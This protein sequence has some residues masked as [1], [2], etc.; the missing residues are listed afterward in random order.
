LQWAWQFAFPSKT[1]CLSP[2]TGHR[3][4]FHC[5]PKSLLLSYT[6]PASRIHRPC[7]RAKFLSY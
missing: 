4:R 1:M 7:E 3:V 6:N 5:H 2:Y